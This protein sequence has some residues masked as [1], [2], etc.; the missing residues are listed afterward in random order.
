MESGKGDR[1]MCFGYST[2]K[3]PAGFGWSVHRTEWNADLQRG[4]ST[5]LKSGTLPTRA[6]ATG[7]ARRWTLFFRRGGQA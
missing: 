3:T 6:R 4:V 7:Q 2:T 5:V 1:G